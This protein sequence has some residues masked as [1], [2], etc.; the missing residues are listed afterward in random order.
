M[1]EERIS[2][3]R[4]LGDTWRLLTFR[5]PRADL[6]RHWRAFLAFGLGMTW[7]AGVGRYW[8]H[9]DAHRLQYFGVGSVVYVF[10]LAALVWVIALPLRPGNWKYR[11]VLTFIT[12]TSPPALVYAVPVERLLSP[13]A[14]VD[15]N[16]WALA[17][18]A[19]WRVA[20]WFRYLG[21]TARL[22]PGAIFVAGIL[23]LTL[24]VTALAH[25]NLER[26]VFEIMGGMERGTSRDGA[27]LVVLALTWI[28]FL[29][30]PVLLVAYAFLV[31][32]AWRSSGAGASRRRPWQ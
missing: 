17:A 24:I 15:A 21:R 30:S 6:D 3:G 29:A 2:P 25:L 19:A 11:N 13:G 27:Y 12:L 22:G 26:A 31:W 20:L 18:V 23:P 28:S 5:D 4:M 14:A 16:A 9:P 7:L 32:R 1:D 8:D 10:V